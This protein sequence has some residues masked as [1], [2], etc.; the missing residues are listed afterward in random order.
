MTVSLA[1]NR[2]NS[3]EAVAIIRKPNSTCDIIRDALLTLKSIDWTDDE[4][5]YAAKRKLRYD[6]WSILSQA[7]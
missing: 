4:I 2:L 6:E 3:S 1:H 5:E 7:Y